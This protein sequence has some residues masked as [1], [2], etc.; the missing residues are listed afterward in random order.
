MCTKT[1]KK[2]TGN[3]RKPGLTGPSRSLPYLYMIYT[4]EVYTHKCIL[5]Y[6]YRVTGKV[7]QYLVKNR[8]GNLLYI[9]Y[10]FQFFFFFQSRYLHIIIFQSIPIQNL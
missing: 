6:L 8:A 3:L 7:L 1:K 9:V 10:E 5:L 4:G 2:R